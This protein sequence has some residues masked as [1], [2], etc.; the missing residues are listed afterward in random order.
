MAKSRRLI[1]GQKGKS[2]ATNWNREEDRKGHEKT[3]ENPWW[4]KEG[5]GGHEN[6]LTQAG[7]LSTNAI[8]KDFSNQTRWEVCTGGCQSTSGTSPEGENN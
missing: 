5:G 1:W 2:Y 7:N 3:R 4:G 8:K 6:G